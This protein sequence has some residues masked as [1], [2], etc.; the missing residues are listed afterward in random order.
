MQ[1]IHKNHENE[2][3]P[4]GVDLLGIPELIAAAFE[5]WLAQNSCRK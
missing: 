4:E 3:Y 5:S 2:A 1:S